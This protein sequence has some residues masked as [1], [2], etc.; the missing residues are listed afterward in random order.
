MIILEGEITQSLP[1][2]FDFSFLLLHTI[3]FN[4]CSSL[5][6]CELKFKLNFNKY[7]HFC[8]QSLLQCL[9]LVIPKTINLLS[10]VIPNTITIIT[11]FGNIFYSLFVMSKCFWIRYY[12]HRY[13]SNFTTFYS[14]IK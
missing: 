14:K 5:T 9:L 7:C 1:C 3:L 11:V 8:A 10:L 6:S 12:V 13:Y 4:F 2:V